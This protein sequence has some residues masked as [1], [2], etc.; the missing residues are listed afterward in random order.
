MRVGLLTAALAVTL[1]AAPLSAQVLGE[2][3]KPGDLARVEIKLT[4]AGTLKV[5]RG[6]KPDALPLTATA[7]HAFDQRVEAADAAGATLAVRHYEIARSQSD[8]AGE[9]STRDLGAD[10]RL[11]VVRRTDSGALHFSPD[12]PLSR[13]E[14]ELVA[15]HFDP[16][17][18]PRLLPNK[19]V[20]AKE[21][22][23]V[24]AD[25]AQRACQLS[26][27]TAA[28]LTGTVTAV[29]PQAVTFTV[30]GTAEGVE[31]GAV[32][33]VTVNATGTFDVAAGRITTLK[34]EQSDVRAQGAASPASEVKATTEL[35]VKPLTEEPKVLDAAARAKVPA[36]GKTPDL[37]TMLRY[38]DA[39]AR[40]SFVYP[41][42]WHVL[43]RT[44]DHLVL[45]LLDGG[46]FVAQ[47]TLTVMKTLD[48][49]ATMPVDEFKRLVAAVPG[50]VPNEVGEDGVIP[51]DAGRRLYHLTALGK[52]DGVPVRQTFYH[53]A[54]PNGEQVALTVLAGADVAGKVG[55]RD[56]SLINAVEFAPP[57]APVK[58]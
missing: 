48:P 22:W 36:D 34:W 7:Q 14:L 49:G 27:L 57:A 44:K 26:G 37:M 52:Q 31:T 42:E 2:T 23:K 12:G 13:E 51:T 4:V 25:A 43:G 1:S 46:E 19:P 11:V 56:V 30:T 53:L 38:T 39:A 55:T 16:L 24:P 58:R 10:R 50:W 28:D 8:S 33:K 6:G 5:E 32:A 45:R 18:L 21:T 41:R 3:A 20:A 40:F 54:G 35:T 29:T 47:A 9:R 15:E 17:A